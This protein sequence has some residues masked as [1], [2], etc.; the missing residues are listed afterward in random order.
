MNLD[1][2]ITQVTDFDTL[3][4]F[5]AYLRHLAIDHE[6]SGAESTAQDYRWMLA[7]LVSIEHDLT[8]SRSSEAPDKTNEGFAVD[9]TFGA[10]KES[11]FY[12]T[13]PDAY[14]S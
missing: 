10:P 11:A 4:Q 6:V 5:K 13:K 8:P 12:P 2:T 7:I 14:Q 3:F 1:Q 9:K